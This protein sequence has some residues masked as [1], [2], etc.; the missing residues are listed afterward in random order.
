MYNYGYTN[1]Y[2]HCV[3]I[4]AN[5]GK[6]NCS[7]LQLICIHHGITTS[8]MCTISALANNYHDC[9]SN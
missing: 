1:N 5:T 7:T 6:Q 3:I 9:L 2:Y 8:L 4:I